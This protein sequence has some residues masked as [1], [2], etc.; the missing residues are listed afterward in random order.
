MRSPCFTILM[1]LTEYLNNPHFIEREMVIELAHPHGVGTKPLAAV[2][3]L[4]DNKIEYQ[5]GPLLGQH[6][7]EVYARYMG[8]TH[9]ELAKLAAEGV[10]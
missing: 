4:S 8:F 3:R 9:H 5:T 1:Y 2:Q 10:I 6:N 7:A